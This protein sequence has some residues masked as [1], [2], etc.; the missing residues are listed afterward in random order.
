MH[1][2]YEI[3]LPGHDFAKATKYKISSHRATKLTLCMLFVRLVQSLQKLFLKFP[4]QV[5]HTLLL[6]VVSMTQA[7]PIP[8]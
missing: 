2:D 1:V 5:K 3:R 8:M 4:I 6:T 7:P